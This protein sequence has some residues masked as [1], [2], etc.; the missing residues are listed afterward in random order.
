MLDSPDK[1]KSLGS[2]KESRAIQIRLWLSTSFILP[3]VKDEPRRKL[4]PEAAPAAEVPAVGVGSSAW[5]GS[6][7]SRSSIE[8]KLAAAVVIQELPQ[9][10]YQLLSLVDRKNDALIRAT[11]AMYLGLRDLEPAIVSR[12]NTKSEFG[13]SGIAAHGDVVLELVVKNG[14]PTTASIRV[15]ENPNGTV[16]LCLG[17]GVL[18]NLL[19]PNVKDEPRL[20][21]ARLVRKHEA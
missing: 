14:E 6:G 11:A 4:A 9:L 20:R 5:F 10:I 21:L 17:R 16:L 7:S 13:R 12:I 19:P 1:R 18:E 15:S 3:N 8:S 2:E